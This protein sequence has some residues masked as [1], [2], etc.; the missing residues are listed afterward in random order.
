MRQ[1]S[2]KR[3]IAFICTKE[4]VLYSLV[5]FH[6]VLLIVNVKKV[7]TLPSMLYRKANKPLY[8]KKRNNHRWHVAWWRLAVVQS[9]YYANIYSDLHMI[10]RQFKSLVLEG[11][12]YT[13]I[14]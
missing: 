14:R 2:I 10:V 12:I 3:L 6:K 1:A 8:A 7:L 5:H 13:Q 4:A 9:E 11:N